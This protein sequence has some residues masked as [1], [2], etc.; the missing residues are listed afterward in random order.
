MTTAQTTHPAPATPADPSPPLRPMFVVGGLYSRANGVAWIMSGLA[1]ALGRQGSP[2]DVYAADCLGRQSIGD[3]FEPPTRWRTAPGLWM[4]GLSVSPSLKPMMRAAM[5]E[6]D[7][8]H[9]H[10]IWMLPNSYA[11]RLAA[12]ADKP[13]LFTAHGALEPWALK[14]SGWK[15]RIVERWFQRRDLEHAA[16]IHTNSYQELEGIRAYGLRCPVAVVPNGVD[17]DLL[18]RPV[19]PAAF[20]E[21]HPELK[22]KRIALFLSRLHVKKGVKHLIEAWA[23]LHKDH[24]DWHLVLA[25]PDNGYAAEARQYVASLGLDRCVT[26]TGNLQGDDK[27]AAFRAAEFFALPSFSEGFSMAVLE[28]MACACPVMITPGCN[29]PEAFESGGA[30]AVEP[31][32]ASTEEG[33]RSLI[34]MSDTDRQHMGQQ[35]RQLV[36]KSYTWDAVAKQM[37]QVYQWLAQGGTPPATVTWD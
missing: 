36:L 37:R 30:I 13:V 19:D 15:K 3:I 23:A 21:K 22:D 1:K 34:T 5:A 7:V 17:L 35:G 24:A 31:N 8:V 25:G 16:C 29:F 2:V 32:A 14:H 20:R 27:V 6:T 33:L 10:S 18:D 9:N 12:K 11:C 26:F 28:A 4:G